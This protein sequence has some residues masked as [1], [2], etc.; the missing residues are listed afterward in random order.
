MLSKGCSMP[1]DEQEYTLYPGD[2]MDSF[3]L[4]A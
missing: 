2:S 4:Q 1:D 3:Q